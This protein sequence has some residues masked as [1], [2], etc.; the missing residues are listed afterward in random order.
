MSISSFLP[1]PPDPRPQPSAPRP[2]P[3]LPTTRTFQGG[4]LTTADFRELSA[5]LSSLALE[6]PACR[7]RVLS[8]LE[9]EQ[10]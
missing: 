2:R 3:P 6:I 5:R 4:A 7:G 10:H 1:P 9:G 8:V